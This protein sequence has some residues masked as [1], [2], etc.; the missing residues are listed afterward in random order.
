M[1][2]YTIERVSDHGRTTRKG[3]RYGRQARVVAT[4]T[5]ESE[6]AG[7]RADAKALIERGSSDW[8]EVRAA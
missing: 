3:E 5:H 2:T 4:T 7:L 8:I 1:T 6:I